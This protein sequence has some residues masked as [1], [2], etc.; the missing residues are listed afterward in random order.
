MLQEHKVYVQ[1]LIKKDI[2]LVSDWIVERS[3]HVY[4]CG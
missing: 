4:I 3:G 1:H 2:A